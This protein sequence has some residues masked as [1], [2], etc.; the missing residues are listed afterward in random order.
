ME[1]VIDDIRHHLERQLD[2]AV[3]DEEAQ[4]HAGQAQADHHG[5]GPQ[6]VG[7]RRTV[8]AGN[9]IHDAAGKQ[10]HHHFG[11]GGDNDEAADQDDPR[12]LSPPVTKGEAEHIAKGIGTEIELLATH[13]LSPAP[14]SG[15]RF[16]EKGRIERSWGRNGRRPKARLNCRTYGKDRLRSGRNGGSR[17][18][19]T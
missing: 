11:Q 9:G 4:H 10:R 13:F 1:T 14:F 16:L 7:R 17:G 6:R 19:R 15:H 12:R 18:T 2:D 5:K 3:E 8:A